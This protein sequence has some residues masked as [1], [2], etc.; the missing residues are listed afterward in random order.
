ML[1]NLI[2]LIRA[3]LGRP[4]ALA[5]VDN[6]LMREARARVLSRLA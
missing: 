1:Q 5:H 3:R 6:V 2:A 4:A